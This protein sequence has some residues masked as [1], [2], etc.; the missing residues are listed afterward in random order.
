MTP[1]RARQLLDAEEERLRSLA[2]T[3]RG[4]LS[5][6]LEDSTGELTAFDQHPADVG[7][8][9]ENREVDLSLLGQFEAEIADIAR[10][11][12]RL[13][14]GTYGHC[15]VCGRDIGDERLEAQPSARLCMEHQRERERETAR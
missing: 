13:D 11:R 9:T 6:S 1:D 12:R 3:E 7:T 14:E 15:E 8:E 5:E 4:H 2:A 10:A